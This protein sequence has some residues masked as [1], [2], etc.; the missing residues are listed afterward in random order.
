MIEFEDCVQDL[1]V[2]DHVF[3][4]PAFTWINNQVDNHQERKLDRML[5]NPKWLDCFLH[6]VVEF[7][8][9]GI[10]DHCSTLIKMESVV[11]NPPKPFKFFNFWIDHSDFLEVVRTFWIDPV[12]GNLM[13]KLHNK[14]KRL[15]PILKSWSA[16]NFS[17]ISERVKAKKNELDSKQK[18]LLETSD[19]AQEVRSLT[20]EYLNLLK[21]EES[22]Y[23]QK[24]RAI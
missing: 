21:A 19:A 2:F 8:I 7:L 23:R 22:F 10:S 14:L 16:V 6:S 4:G 1:D 17:I 24:S 18:V 11:F 15:K 13:K 9:P 3:V 5:I 12:E 20:D